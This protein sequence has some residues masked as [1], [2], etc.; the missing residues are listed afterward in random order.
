MAEAAVVAVQQSL[1]QTIP[2][3]AEKAEPTAAEAEA[4]K[5]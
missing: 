4:E 1:Q 3:K 2:V 5:V